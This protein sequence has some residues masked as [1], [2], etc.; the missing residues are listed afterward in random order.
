MMMSKVKI[1]Y[2]ARLYCG[3]TMVSEDVVKL[4]NRPH[5]NMHATAESEWCGD[6]EIEILFP[7]R[8]VPQCDKIWIGAF[9]GDDL[10]EEW[11]LLEVKLDT[12]RHAV[13]TA[14]G[15]IDE[16]WLPYEYGSST[17]ETRKEL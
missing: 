11:E 4:S 14:D 10:L 17:W 16:I 12:M 7:H 6:G 3:T 9:Q 2:V 8:H 15:E 1:R 5:L 13:L